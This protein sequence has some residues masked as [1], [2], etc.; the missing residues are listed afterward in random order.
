MNNLMSEGYLSWHMFQVCID[1]LGSS[2]LSSAACQAYYQY[3]RPDMQVS[4]H[5]TLTLLK[6]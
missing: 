5:S 1:F 6:G 3:L 2:S 4:Q